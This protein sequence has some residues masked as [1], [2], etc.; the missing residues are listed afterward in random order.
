MEQHRQDARCAVC[1]Q[2]MDPLGFALENF[3]AIGAWRTTD[4]EDPID[5]SGELPGG[6]RFDGLGGLADLLVSS[7]KAEFIHCVAEKLLTYGLG[8]GLEYYDQCAVNDIVAAWEREDY[9]FAALVVE[10]SK[11][12]PFRKR[13]QLRSTQ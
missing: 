2:K 12:E 10:V 5:A 3:D 9:R 7:K 8:R 13:R 4:G 11:S 1:H 6:E